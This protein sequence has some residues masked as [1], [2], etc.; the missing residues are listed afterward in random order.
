MAV[1][2]HDTAATH[3]ANYLALDDHGLRTLLQDAVISLDLIEDD[4]D[5]NGTSPSAMHTVADAGRMM[6]RARAELLALCDAAFE[7]VFSTSG[8]D[9]GA[10]DNKA[11]GNDS[12]AAWLRYWRLYPRLDEPER[13]LEKICVYLSQRVVRKEFN[14][15]VAEGGTMSSCA[16]VQPGITHTPLPPCSLL[17]RTAH[18]T[19]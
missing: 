18:T 9:G 16:Y 13:G 7:G 14:A 10:S 3:V 19:V 5:T 6:D 11:T 2:D 4:D 17:C 12:D 15:A 1:A 8:K